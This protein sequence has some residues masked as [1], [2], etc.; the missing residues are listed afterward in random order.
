[1]AEYTAGTIADKINYYKDHISS[2]RK[3]LADPSVPEWEK[4]LMR[5]ETPKWERGLE[6]LQK[7]RE[8][9]PANEYEAYHRLAGEVEARQVQARQRLTP[10][11]RQTSLPMWADVP[12]EQ[13]IVRFGGGG[14]SMSA[15]PPL[16]Q[17]MGVPRIHA[18]YGQRP[19]VAGIRSA[20]ENIGPEG[21]SA[22]DMARR[23]GYGSGEFSSMGQGEGFLLRLIRELQNERGAQ[24]VRVVE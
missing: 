11:E 17:L 14:A 2:N 18:D 1:M 4:K 9:A 5:E 16:V 22:I 23:E 24:P 13:Q 19:P 10:E 3:R 6:K 12:Q 7:E 21:P 15:D 8:N 20:N